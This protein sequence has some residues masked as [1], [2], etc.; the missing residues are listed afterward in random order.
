MR[1]PGNAI[2]ATSSQAAFLGGS[3][4]GL[5]FVWTPHSGRHSHG[6]LLAKS[7]VDLNQGSQ[8]KDE[9]EEIERQ[10]REYERMRKMLWATMRKILWAMSPLA[11]VFFVL[12][13]VAYFWV[14]QE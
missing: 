11:I 12:W 5:K 7:D 4:G 13:I 14:L 2:T 10:R 6:P 9:P 3:G 1:P 8:M